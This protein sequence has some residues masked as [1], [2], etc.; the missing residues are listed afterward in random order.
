MDERIL[1]KRF[2]F[3]FGSQFCIA[4]VMYTLM[5]TITE[6][7]SSMGTTATV[8]GLVSGIYVFGGLCS[9]LYS[10]RAL[11]TVGWKRLAVIF[12]SI[13]SVACLF[14]FLV[15]NVWLLLF[16]RFVHGIGFGAS[17]NAVMTIGMSIL[18]EKRFAEACGYF[19][20][21][22][23][24]AV[25]VGP[26]FG[27]MMYDGFG[28][29]GCF[30][31]AAL[32]CFASLLFIL[33]VDVSDVDPAANRADAGTKKAA[34]ESEDAPRGINRILEVRALPI[35]LVTGL[36]ALGYVSVMSFYRLYAVETELTEIFSKFFLLYAFILVFSRPFAGKLQDKYGD[37]IVCYP[38]IIVQTIGLVLLA[39]CPNAFTVILC[40]IGCALGYGTLNSAC[41]A[42]ACRNTSM[43][44]RSYAVTTF[45]IC[46]DAAMGIGPALLGAVQSVTGSYM[47]MYIAAA[48]FTLLGLPICMKTLRK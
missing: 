38:G 33:L 47:V 17:A 1:T 45:Y 28:S 12:L 32:L 41:N 5:S 36:S 22:T 31:M 34:E 16:V 9:R 18:P 19:M 46:C 29:M 24:L 42:I 27:G 13:H 21:S 7:A 30:A 48:V 10:G 44:R 20:M 4:M 39:L 14:Y 3:T 26:F 6:Y 35:A 15:D 11:E 43:E 37:K 40:A 23:T 2:L 8:A 25:G